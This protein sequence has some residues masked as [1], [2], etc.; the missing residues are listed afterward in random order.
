MVGALSGC[1][2]YL[3]GSRVRG[4][5]V[6]SSDVDLLLL[7]DVSIDLPT[8]AALR[9]VLEEYAL[10]YHVDIVDA[11][12]LDEPTRQHMLATATRLI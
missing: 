3:F 8:I 5:A 9:E 7:A 4:D 2:V 10:P 1:S 12:C 6:R 11:G